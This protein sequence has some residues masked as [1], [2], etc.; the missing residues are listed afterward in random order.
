QPQQAAQQRFLG[1]AEQ[2]HVGRALR[3]A[4][5]RRQRD[6]QHLH[7]FMAGIGRAWIVQPAK[8]LLEF[9]HPTPLSI[10]ESSSES[11]LFADAIRR[12]NPYAIPL[13]ASGG[14]KG[15]GAWMVSRSLSSGRPLR[16]GPVGS[17]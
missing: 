2:R 9:A 10:W 13:P 4:Q 17:Q 12:S 16:A 14:G 15:G 5:H 1:T 3:P 6:E 7:Q 8:N 11:I